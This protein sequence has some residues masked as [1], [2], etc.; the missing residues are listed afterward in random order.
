LTLWNQSGSRVNRGNLL[1]IP[2]EKSFIYVEP[3]YLQSETSK[4]PEL[5]RVVVAYGDRVAMEQTL[6]AAL[7][8]I[9]GGGAAPPSAAPTPTSQTPGQSP[10][11][12]VQRLASQAAEQFQRAEA[13]Q[14]Q[15]DWAGY[16][17]QM[18]KLQ[19]TLEQ[20]KRATE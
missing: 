1:V 8:Q 19:Q 14:R 17:E 13:L 6:D 3:L 20:L 10:S 5:K 11:S 15:G 16:G 9:F 4:I 2:I 7:T 18:K 12:D